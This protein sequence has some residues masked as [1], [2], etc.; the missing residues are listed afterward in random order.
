ME[1]SQIRVLFSDM[2]KKDCPPFQ[3]L[4]ARLS[5]VEAKLDEASSLSDDAVKEPRFWRQTWRA[6]FFTTTTDSFRRLCKLQRIVIHFTCD[7]N[8]ES[9]EAKD[10]LQTLDKWPI[11][12]S[13]ID[14]CLGFTID[15]ALYILHMNRPEEISG[16]S[17]L[18]MQSTEETL[19]MDD[20]LDE[21]NKKRKIAVT[22]PRET[23]TAR[24]SIAVETLFSFMYQLRKAQH[25]MVLQKNY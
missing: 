4:L 19:P 25:Q 2:Q 3:D 18:L 9:K 11:I 5:K 23:L 14:D 17:K 24:L 20:L 12:M 15:L 7:H 22:T 6:S 10:L 8:P 13:E 16:L 1:Q 21:M